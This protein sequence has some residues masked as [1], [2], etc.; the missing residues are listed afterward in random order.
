MRGSRRHCS[1]VCAADSAIRAYRAMRAR[2]YGGDAY[3]FGEPT[4]SDAGFRLGRA[5]RFD[6]AMALLTLNESVY[7]ASSA[8]YVARGD[9]QLMRR[10]TTAAEAAFREALRRDSANREARGRIR[11]I[12]RTP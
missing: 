7:P 10:D 9:V 3:D 12:G 11:A 2:H 1:I 4:L 5:G 6:D 8:L